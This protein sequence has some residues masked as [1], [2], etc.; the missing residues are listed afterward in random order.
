MFKEVCLER[1][2]KTS[3]RCV[4]LEPPQVNEQILF[5]FVLG[6]PPLA[7]PA[8]AAADNFLFFL[9]FLNGIFLVVREA[10]FNWRRRS[11]GY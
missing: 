2:V 10:L 6:S 11:G 8:A 4:K 3:E 7:S 1:C 9:R 5:L